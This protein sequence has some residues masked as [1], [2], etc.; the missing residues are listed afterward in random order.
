M[1]SIIEVNGKWRA[2]VRRKGLPTMTETFGT[3]AQGKR[4]AQAWAARVETE[5]NEGRK[6]GAHGITGKTFADA[7]NQYMNEVDRSHTY[8]YTLKALLKCE[9]A[10][11]Q[12]KSMTS[13]M[14]VKYICGRYADKDGV[15]GK[16]VNNTHLSAIRSV[17][18][19]A[20]YGWNWHVPLELFEE[21]RKRLSVLGKVGK[22]EERTRRPTERELEQ[23]QGYAWRK[24][25]ESKG[26]KN[27]TC[28]MWDI[29]MFAIHTAMRR[30]EI[31]RIQWSDLNLEDKTIV[32]RDRKHPT[33]KKGN[34]K[35]VPLLDE[36]LEIIMRQPRSED[37]DRIFPF[38]PNKLTEDF[39]DAVRELGIEDL[40]FHDFRHEG[41]SRL[42][43]IGYPIEVVQMFTGHED[44][45]MLKRYTQ[46]KPKNLKR[47]QPIPAAVVNQ[48]EVTKLAMEQAQKML[49]QMLTAAAGG[50][51][52]P[53]V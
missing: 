32:I 33:K 35:V 34:H 15:D 29:I 7:I 14:V 48:D 45:A 31:T 2:Q 11:V 6:V 44:W 13:D 19:R 18:T 41:T 8:M 5:I 38:R 42:F 9:L 28:P 43:E 25:D 30:A 26:H 4:D 17:L 10:P 20:K 50:M 23:L 16:V 24:W 39:R 47:I 22:S 27:R 40:V 3:G 21:P 52:L 46:I 51:T 1:A 37:E 53:P 12:L 36:A 49:Q